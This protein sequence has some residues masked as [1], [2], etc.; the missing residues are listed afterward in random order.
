MYCSMIMQ[1]RKEIPA[2]GHTM[3][4][5]KGEPATCTEPGHKD[6][7]ICSTCG[8]DEREEIP[9]LGHDLEEHK[10]VPSTCETDGHAAYKICKREGCG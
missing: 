5:E 4:P 6:G 8:F 1:E 9:A 7:E 3:V 2:L 10:A